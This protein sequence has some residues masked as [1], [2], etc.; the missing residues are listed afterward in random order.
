[1][2]PFDHMRRRLPPTAG[3]KLHYTTPAYGMQDRW[4]GTW[5]TLVDGIGPMKGDWRM[6]SAHYTTQGIRGWLRYFLTPHWEQT[7][8]RHWKPPIFTRYGWAESWRFWTGAYRNRNMKFDQRHRWSK[9]LF[10]YEL[11]CLRCGWKIN[12][13]SIA[14]F[15]WNPSSEDD[16]YWALGGNDLFSNGCCPRRV[17]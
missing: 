2:L 8:W 12:V 13:K 14:H 17:N 3:G 11:D 1:M 6:D 4:G 9:N 5:Y 15:S 10:A 16:I 7:T